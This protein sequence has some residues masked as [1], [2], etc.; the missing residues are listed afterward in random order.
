MKKALKIII[1]ILLALLVIGSVVWYLLVYDPGFTRDV[2]LHEARRQES[3]GNHS[4]AAWFYNQAYAQSDGNEDVAI[5]LAEQFKSIGNYTKAEYTLSNAIANGG[6]TKLYTALCK[7]YVE[8]DKL[9]DAVTMLENVADP[10]IKAELDA[11]RPASPA[12]TPEPGFYTQY[13]QVAI[14]AQSGTLYIN[15][16]GEYP[17]TE[18]APYAEPITLP[19]GETTI[20]ALAVGED[21]LVSKLVVCGYTV[22]GVV[23]PVT[24][25]DAAVENAVRDVLDITADATIYT[26][27]LWNITSFEMPAEAAVYDDLAYM[28]YLRELHIQNSAVSLAP[29]ADLS[30]LET[31]DLTGCRPTAEDM[32]VIGG[33]INLKTLILADCS[34][35]S[36][37]D[38]ADLKSLQKLDLSGNTIRNIQILS[39]MADLQ[40]LHMPNNALTS[41]DPLSGLA[42][43]H[44]LDVSY[45]SLASAA[46]LSSCSGLT[47]LDISNNALTGI[48]GLNRLSNLSHLNVSHNQISDISLL[49]NS[50][51]LKELNVS[52]NAITDITCLQALVGLTDLDFSYNSVTALPVWPEDC[53]LI[54]I[55]GS[56]NQ[57]ESIDE[58]ANFWNLNHVYMEYN[59]LT[60]IDALADCPALVL[61]NVYGNAITDVS[62]LTAHDIVVNY[63]PV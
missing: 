63:N 6:S 49:A 30:S 52:N 9:L 40:E 39:S 36:I 21:G 16:E 18:D 32:T 51:S 57:L 43:L 10:A 44:T 58:L 11:L 8:Q 26:N 4:A 42:N 35:S 41:L 2:L 20:Y 28:P 29:L 3:K 14:E 37:A 61:V 38:L 56:Y 47:W 15:T 23:E 48:D 33:L 12:F 1:P 31:L 54:D 27:D 13:I 7:T 24:F 17:S 5:E 59:L 25:A 62:A 19:A 46:A 45:N 34:L 53:A 50:T 60:N 55:N 22:G